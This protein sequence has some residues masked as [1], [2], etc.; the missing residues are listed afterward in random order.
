DGTVSPA[1]GTDLKGPTA[2]LK[3]VAK[4]DHAHTYTHL[5]N[6]RFLPQFLEGEN[7]EAFVSY[8]RSFIEL[9]IHHIQ[10]NIIDNKVLL[11]AQ[12]HPEKHV[13]LVVRVAGFSAYF[14]ALEK[15]VQ[16]QIIARTQ[17]TAL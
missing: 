7:R 3:S 11:D 5:L 13:D 9:G 4:A 17:H 16:N 10:F 14:V 6:Q 2:I 15:P 12:Q 1:V 8:L